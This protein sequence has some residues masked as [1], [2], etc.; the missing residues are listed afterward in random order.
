MM[1][2]CCQIDRKKYIRQDG[3]VDMDR[4]MAALHEE[5]Q[6]STIPVPDPEDICRCPCH[7]DGQTVLC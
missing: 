5:H 1:F 6:S 2:G 3:T 7:Q 4:L